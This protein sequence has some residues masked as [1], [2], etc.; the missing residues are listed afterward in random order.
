MPHSQGEK[1]CQLTPTEKDEHKQRRAGKSLTAK[2]KDFSVQDQ[3]LVVESRDGSGGL[4]L[5]S[6]GS[7]SW[8]NKATP[9]NPL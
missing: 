8:R 1:S 7:F 9:V 3:E 5:I 4:Q 6:S 2:K